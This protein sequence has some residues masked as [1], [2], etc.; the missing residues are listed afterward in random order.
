M[1][2]CARA[3]VRQRAVNSP[4]MMQ[5]RCLFCGRNSGDPDHLLHCDGR[6]GA[7]EALANA[8]ED[9]RRAAAL[10]TFPALVAA[11]ATPETFATSEAAA[12]SVA[13]TKEQ[14][15]ASVYAC[16]RSAGLEG[17]TD[18]EIQT[19]LGLDGNSERPRRW[20]LQQQARVAVKRD[21]Q[22]NAFRR[23]TPGRRKAVVWVATELAARSAGFGGQ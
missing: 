5:A 13:D 20:E 6:Q 18:H 9:A 7:V 22:G 8:S 23:L 3:R 2:L 21:G 11:G 14:Q 17:R 16:I 10:P 4:T 15:R 19:A 1:P 12:I